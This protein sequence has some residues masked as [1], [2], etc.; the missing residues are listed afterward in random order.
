MW[1]G[2][3]TESFKPTGGIRQGDPLSL[4]LF[5]LC[6]EKLS[7]LIND[8]MLSRKWCTIRAGRNGPFISHLF[9]ANDILLFGEASS[10]QVTCMLECLHSFCEASRQR[11]SVEKTRIFFSKKTPD[12]V[13]D[14]VVTMS[15]FVETDNLG[16]YLGMPLITW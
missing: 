13:R 2:D 12:F 15:S 6:L 11:V 8:K 4:Y 3:R 10:S 7:H 16:T 9:F 1:N 14:E 5:V